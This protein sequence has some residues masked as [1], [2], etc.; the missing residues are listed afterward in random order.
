[1]KTSL[2]LTKFKTGRKH[3]IAFSEETT[4][5]ILFIWLVNDRRDKFHKLW[6]LW[7][8]SRKQIEE[9]QKQ[10]QITTGERLL[11]WHLSLTT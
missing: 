5:V 7:E 6:K 3:K 1:M 8:I 11:S 2:D 4:F 9:N 10:S